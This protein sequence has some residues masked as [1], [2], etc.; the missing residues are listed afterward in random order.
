MPSSLTDTIRAAVAAPARDASGFDVH[1]ALATASAV[2]RRTARESV[3]K[4]TRGSESMPI[5]TG[6]AEQETM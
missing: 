6:Q 1:A 3:A 5:S 4:P 2:A